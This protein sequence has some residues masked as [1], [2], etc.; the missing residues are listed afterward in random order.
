MMWSETA[1]YG[2]RDTCAVLMMILA[3][4][5]SFPFHKNHHIII[6][7]LKISHILVKVVIL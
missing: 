7:C 5:L 6:S 4:F 3:Y 1:T 2:W